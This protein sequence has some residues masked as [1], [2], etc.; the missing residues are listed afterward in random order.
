[1]AYVRITA[2]LTFMGL[3][4]CQKPTESCMEMLDKMIPIICRGYNYGT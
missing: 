1:M 2:L 3:A 4:S